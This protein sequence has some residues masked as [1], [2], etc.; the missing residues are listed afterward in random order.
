MKY[1]FAYGSCMDEKRL[2]TSGNAH[3][4]KKI[5]YAKINGYR[6]RMNKLALNKQSVYANIEPDNSSSVYGVLYEIDDQAEKYLDIREGYPV[7]YNKIYTN[8]TIDGRTYKDVLV[9]VA[10]DDWICKE[11]TPVSPQYAEELMRGCQGLPEP[12]KSEFIKEVKRVLQS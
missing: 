1:Y 8:A 12:Y 7:H 6:F 9:Y 4:F 2:I 3:R 11:F 10:N 5:G